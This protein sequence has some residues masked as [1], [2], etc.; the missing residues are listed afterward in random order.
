DRLLSLLGYN[1]DFDLAL[2]DVEDGIRR[3]TLGEDFFV[4]AIRPYS[5]AATHA[6]EKGLHIEWNFLLGFGHR[7]LS[8]IFPHHCAIIII[9]APLISRPL[10]RTITGRWCSILN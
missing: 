5:P 7:F 9:S 8:P 2:L 1:A 10:L 3:L 4:F 6:V